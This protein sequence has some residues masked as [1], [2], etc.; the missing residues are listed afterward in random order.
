MPEPAATPVAETSLLDPATGLATATAWSEVFRHEDA[1]L[2]RYGHPVT[3]VALE[4]HRL[5]DLAER[6]GQET[7]DRLI[8]AVAAT[9]QRSARSSDLVARQSHSRFMV[10]MPETDEIRAINFVERVRDACDTWLEASA[11]SIRL[12]I[13]WASAGPGGDLDDALRLAIER[14]Q[15]DRSAGLS[16]D[17]RRRY[18]G[19]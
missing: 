11:V 7:A 3:I 14:M 1:R 19:R 6:F 18:V 17:P 2:D 8:P 15:A 5:D 12:A 13:G 4:L 9:I 16:P 10:L